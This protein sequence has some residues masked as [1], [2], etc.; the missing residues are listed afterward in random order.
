MKIRL[1]GH[2]REPVMQVGIAGPWFDFEKTLKSFSY[3]IAENNYGEMISALVANSHSIKAIEECNLNQVPKNRRILVLWEPKIVNPQT[4]SKKTLNNYG[5]IF[6]PSVDWAE[7][8]G[9][10]SF[11][12]PQLDLQNNKPNFANWEQRQNKAIIVLA[13]KFSACKGELYSLRRELAYKTRNQD[14]LDLYGSKWNLGAMYDLRHYVG[15]FL[16][17][18]LKDLSYVSYR[19]LMRKHK[20]FK[21]LSEDKFKTMANYKISVVI[22]NSADYISEKLFDSVSSGAIT[23]YVGPKIVKYG[24]DEHAV[25]QCESNANKIKEK[26]KEIQSLPAQEQLKIAKL[27]YSSLL[28]SSSSWECHTV[29]RNLA[30]RVNNYLISTMENTK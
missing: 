5:K 8:L 13:N 1:I 21:G 19:Y 6:T 20:N 10:E 2:L 14:L 22:E 12:W 9:S 30:I 11:L 7:N 29:L 3:E 24:L 17:T 28:I 26:I 25:I 18:P 23:I 15:N 16:R 4:Y 27:Q